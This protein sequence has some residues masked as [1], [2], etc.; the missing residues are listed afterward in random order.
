MTELLSKRHSNN[1]IRT[2]KIY[3]NIRISMNSNYLDRL[4]ENMELNEKTKS[5]LETC[6]KSQKMP[7]LLSSKKSVRFSENPKISEKQIKSIF[8]DFLWKK[9]IIIKN[10]E[11]IQTDNKILENEQNE[12]KNEKNNLE[13]NIK[14]IF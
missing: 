3:E 10:E 7:N 5:I 2:P 4:M 9:E 11:K 6:A 13:N 8:L 14:S 1:R 12:C